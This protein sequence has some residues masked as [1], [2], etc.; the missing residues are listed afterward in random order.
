MAKFGT[1]ITHLVVLV[2][3]IIGL[4]YVV[5]MVTNHQGSKLVPNF[6]IGK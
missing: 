3:I 1:K 5:H 2:L 4:F 6:G